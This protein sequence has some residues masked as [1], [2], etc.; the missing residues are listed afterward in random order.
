MHIW[1]DMI[2]T[3]F[4]SRP[5][6]KR[7]C[8]SRFLPQIGDNW[9]TP[10]SFGALTFNNKWEDRNIYARFNT[11]DDPSTSDKKLENFGPVTPEFCK[12]VCAG[13]ATHWALPRILALSYMILHGK[14]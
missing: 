2:D 5:L 8:G 13:R 12:R 1:V 10:P 11:A 7:C 4:F 14:G 6:K 9:Y 3:I